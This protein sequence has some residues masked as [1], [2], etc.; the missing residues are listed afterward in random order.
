MPLMTH[1]K[2][3]AKNFAYSSGKPVVNH[4]VDYSAVDNRETNRAE[5]Y[6]VSRFLR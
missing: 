1:G 5:Q 2:A 6:R 3:T 4:L